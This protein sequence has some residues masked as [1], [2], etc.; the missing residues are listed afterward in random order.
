MI[1][2]SFLPQYGYTVHHWAAI[3]GHR[4]IVD[5]LLSREGRLKKSY[6][7]SRQ[8]AQQV[9]I[10][11]REV[12][13][14]PVGESSQDLGGH[15]QPDVRNPPRTQTTNVGHAR[16]PS[17]IEPIEDDAQ[18]PNPQELDDEGMLTDPASSD[19]DGELS[20]LGRRRSSRVPAALPSR[21]SV[22][23]NTKYVGDVRACSQ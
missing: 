11:L 5:L 1:R 22:A 17:E 15:V 7:Q 8:D 16:Q 23:I 12:T 13:T 20:M 9:T 10:T 6:N 4:K 19:D 14:N 3:K 18:L 2:S 21:S